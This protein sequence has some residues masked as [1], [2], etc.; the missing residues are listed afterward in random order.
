MRDLRKGID[1]GKSYRLEIYRPSAT[2][3]L[4]KAKIYIHRTDAKHHEPSVEH[5]WDEELNAGLIELGIRAVDLENE[6][7]RFALG[8]RDALQNV[9]RE[10]GNGYFN[11]VLLD[12][13]KES[14]LTRYAEIGEVLQYTYHDAT[15]RDARQYHLCRDS[16]AFGIS[17]RARELVHNLK[18]S[19]DEAK[20]ILPKAIA[21]YIDNRFSVSS[22]RQMGLL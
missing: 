17:G 13:I 8:L 20:E 15:E 21:K 10:Y 2:V 11:A 16:I 6:A 18:Y 7:L 3:G 4:I 12:L 19:E 14:D 22:R 5:D 9:E 1:D